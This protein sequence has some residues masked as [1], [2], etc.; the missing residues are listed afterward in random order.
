MKR[1]VLHL[2]II[3]L[4]I[5]LLSG[6]TEKGTAA[7]R[8]IKKPIP[9]NNKTQAKATTTSNSKVQSQV[10]AKA[11]SIIE[12]EPKIVPKSDYPIKGD[13][14]SPDGVVTF[15]DKY[16]GYLNYDIQLNPRIYA[17]Q[18]VVIT[19]FVYKNADFK[20]NEFKVARLQPSYC[21]DPAYV[22]GLVCS[23]E[24]ASDLKK[25]EW[26]TV[27]GTIIVKIHKNPKTNFEYE[28]VYVEPESI[29]KIPMRSDYSL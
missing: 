22:L 16:F 2:L 6:F 26:V 9:T 28:E 8:Y 19:G 15:D 12:E 27:K 1:I 3:F 29:E 20:K 24:K 13:G 7:N 18:K 17:G 11:Y 5:T 25:D 4:T 21:A 23:T 10:D 14:I